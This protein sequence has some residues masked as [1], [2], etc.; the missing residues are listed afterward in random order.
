MDN[1]LARFQYATALAHSSEQ[2]DRREALLHLEYLV[3]HASF[4]LRDCLYLLATVRYLL[5]DYEAARTCA[6]ELCRLEPDNYQAK[7]LHIAIKY[8]HD[9]VTEEKVEQD[10]NV[11][12]A[13]G[14]GMGAAVLGLGLAFLLRNRK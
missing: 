14:V 2:E 11:S 12:I 6:E 9:Q 1:D 4:Y 13:V 7:N 8:K 3:N 5:G 10:K